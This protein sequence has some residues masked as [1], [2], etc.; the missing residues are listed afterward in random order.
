MHLITHIKMH[1]YSHT[2]VLVMRLSTHLKMHS[3]SHTAASDTLDSHINMHSYSH[4]GA[5]DSLDYS[6]QGAQLLTHRC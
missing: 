2:Q 1:S 3:Y 6:H 4:T 5:C